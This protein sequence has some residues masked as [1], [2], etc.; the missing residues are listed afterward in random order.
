MLLA[1]NV[2]SA[3]FAFSAAFLWWRASRRRVISNY[4]G[5]ASSDANH[6]SFHGSAGSILRDDDGKWVDVVA[7]ARK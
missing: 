3:I 5:A 1:L 7:T 6:L 4:S 2:L